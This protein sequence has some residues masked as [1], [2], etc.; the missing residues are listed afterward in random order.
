MPNGVTYWQQA[1]AAA[2]GAA[3]AVQGRGGGGGVSPAQLLQTDCSKKVARCLGEPVPANGLGLV[4]ASAVT[5]LVTDSERAQ[6]YNMSLGGSKL[7]QLQRSAS[8]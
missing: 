3:G 7:A 6:S 2:L 1:A 8:S 5:V 4:L